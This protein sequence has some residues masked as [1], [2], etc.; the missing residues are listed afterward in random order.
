MRCR[1][2]VR[3][4][5]PLS[6]ERHNGS[7]LRTGGGHD[8]GG[9]GDSSSEAMEARSDG[10]LPPRSRMFSPFSADGTATARHPIAAQAVW[11]QG[12]C[13]GRGDGSSGDGN[14][15]AE[16]YACFE[17]RGGGPRSLLPFA[18]ELG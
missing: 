11:L 9:S 17:D 13:V 3:V 16:V 2:A 18:V 1:Y 6:A 15:S 8:N 14:G 4:A 7:H 10:R 12:M 5:L